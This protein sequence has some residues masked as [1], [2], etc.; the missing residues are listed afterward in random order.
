[1]ISKCSS[2]YKFVKIALSEDDIYVR[3]EGSSEWD[4]AAGQAIIES[5]DGKVMCL[6]TLDRLKYSKP[7]L[8]NTAFMS[9]RKGIEI[10]D[11]DMKSLKI[12]LNENNNFSSW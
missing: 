8:R 9:F 10:I 12:E 4:T 2:A 6:K 11:F 7:F 5:N 1:M 3:F